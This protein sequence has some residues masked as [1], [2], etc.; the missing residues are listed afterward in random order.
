MIGEARV[1]YSA[2]CAV[3]RFGG[4][5]RVNSTI[6]RWGD[7]CLGEKKWSFSA[8]RGLEKTEYRDFSPDFRQCY[9]SSGHG[10]EREKGKKKQR[11]D[12]AWDQ[13]ATAT[14]GF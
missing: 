5:K 1:H 7:P 4:G 2:R 11:A 3:K 6:Q 9:G 8:E 14:H 13:I 10:R 12:Q